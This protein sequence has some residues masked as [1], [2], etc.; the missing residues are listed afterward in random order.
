MLALFVVL[1][2]AALLFG[3]GFAVKFLWVLAAIAFVV[4]LIGFVARGANAAWYRW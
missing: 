3:I 1:L 2:F 4:W